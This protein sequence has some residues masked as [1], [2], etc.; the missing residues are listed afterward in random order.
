MEKSDWP[1]I[2][3]ALVSVGL[4]I[5]F[6]GIFWGCVFLFFSALALAGY[7][8]LWNRGVRVSGFPVHN[9]LNLRVTARRD[10]AGDEL[11]LHSIEMWDEIGQ[12]FCDAYSGTFPFTL[13]GD[14]TGL[15]KR[16]RR[17]FQL[18]EFTDKMR[19]IV[20]GT[21]DGRFIELALRNGVFR[22]NMELRWSGGTK[23][24]VRTIREHRLGYPS[25]APIQNRIPISQ[26]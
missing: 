6:G 7:F 12:R 3:L 2:C 14:K 5:L 8:G 10:I 9:A 26:P 23:R 24:I 25:S 13:F 20:R 19:P 21:T 18:V 4:T 11:I 1:A 16:K 22:F 15:P 17:I